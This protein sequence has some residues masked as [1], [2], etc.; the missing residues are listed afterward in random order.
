MLWRMKCEEL[1]T[2]LGVRIRTVRKAK[3]MTQERLAELADLN[4]SYL[5]EV[6]RGLANVSLCITNQIAN[7]LGVCVADLLEEP[8]G[9][10][11]SVDFLALRQKVETLD[12]YEQVLFME[13]ANGIVNG[14]LKAGKLLPLK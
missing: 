6:E 12:K 2:Y 4:L 14:L 3:R 1:L 8:P 10:G 11:A 7:A 9:D 13:T 5:S